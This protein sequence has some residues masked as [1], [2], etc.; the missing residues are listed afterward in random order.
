MTRLF[1]KTKETEKRRVLRKHST[2]AETVLW[3]HL[4]NKQLSGL[5][6]RRQFS[7]NSYVVDFYCSSLKLAIEIDGS[8]H[9]QQNVQKMD[10]IRQEQIESLGV[11]FLRL[12]NQEIINE[13]N[14]IKEKILSL[15]PR[16]NKER[17]QG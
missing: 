15:I 4:R 9:E 17:D 11:T 13:V 16:L 12:T 14:K 1:N 3:L 7:I 8:S 2:T 10:K 6:F 5:K